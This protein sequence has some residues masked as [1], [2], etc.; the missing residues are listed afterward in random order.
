MDMYG[1]GAGAYPMGAPRFLYP[2]A[3]PKEVDPYKCAFCN[4]HSVIPQLARDCEQRHLAEA[5]QEAS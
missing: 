2:V 3:M 4:K 5:E 1:H